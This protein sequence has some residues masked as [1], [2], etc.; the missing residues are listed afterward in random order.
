MRSIGRDSVD[1]GRRGGCAWCPV[2]IRG[3]AVTISNRF[4]NNEQHDE[5][6]DRRTEDYNDDDDDDAEPFL[7]RSFL[8]LLR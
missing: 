7:Y 2:A 5:D 8:S 3:H 4:S 1:G 6:E